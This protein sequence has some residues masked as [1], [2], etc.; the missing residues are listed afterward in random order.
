[1]NQI[2]MH[3]TILFTRTAFTFNSLGHC[4]MA[5]QCY[6]FKTKIKEISQQNFKCIIPLLQYIY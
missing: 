3:I 4:P 5:L 1:M 6:T 2:D